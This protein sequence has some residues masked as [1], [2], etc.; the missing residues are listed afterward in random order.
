MAV[1]D[2]LGESR[3]AT[4]SSRKPTGR[5]T[6]S[7]K[8]T[9]KKKSAGKQPMDVALAVLKK[10]PKAVYADVRAAGTKQGVRITS[11]II[12][13]HARNKLGIAQPQ[14]KKPARKT[15]GTG[16]TAGTG[17]RAATVAFAAGHMKKNPSITMSELK[18]LAGKKH[19][20]YPLI[21]G[22]ARKELGWERPARTVPS[23]RGPGRPGS[24]PARRGPGRPRKV[25]SSADAI[26]AIV[27]RMN[28]LERENETL[29]KTISRIADLASAAS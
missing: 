9:G 3:L 8:A 27:D 17:E 23:R 19:N 28:E 25:A 22:L 24:A 11:P 16:A 6:A 1:Q 18:K 13:R 15:A 5:K 14:T 29:R 26:S 4:K 7:N 21:L 20:I 10:N 2:T 12:M